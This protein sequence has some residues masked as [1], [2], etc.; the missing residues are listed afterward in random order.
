M[1]IRTI[2]IPVQDLA[3]AKALYTG[4]LGTEP[5]MDQPYY[6][7]FRPADTPE[8]GLAPG[9]DVA[10]GPITYYHVSD[11]EATVSSL[12]GL[13][14]TVQQPAKDVGGGGLTAT[15]RDTDG[16]LFGLFQGAT[17]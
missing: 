2:T 17:E 3:A 16:N 13:G 9:G 11:I 6:V 10:A 8:I 5:Y 7:G 14:A 15:L 4:L 1:T 12:T